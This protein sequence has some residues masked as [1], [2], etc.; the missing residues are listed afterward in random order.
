MN[1]KWCVGLFAAAVT[2]VAPVLPAKADPIYVRYKSAPQ[3]INAAAWTTVTM[4]GGA[5]NY[6]VPLSLTSQRRVVGRFTAESD[7]YG[8]STASGYCPVRIVYQNTATGAITEFF[9]QVGTDFAFDTKDAGSSWHSHAISR[10]VVLPAGNYRVYVQGY[11]TSAG[12]TLRL[13][14]AHLEV[15]LYSP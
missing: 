9:P 4:D 15:E 7:C 13:D 12:V 1:K 14:D 5:N 3:T 2:L 11:V 10:S 8:A 6:Y